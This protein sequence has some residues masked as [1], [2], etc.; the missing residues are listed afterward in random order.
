MSIIQYETKI[1]ISF[2]SEHQYSLHDK[3]FLLSLVHSIRLVNM[4]YYTVTSHTYIYIHTYIHV[5]TYIRIHTYIHTYLH[6]YV[7]THIHTYVR[8]VLVNYNYN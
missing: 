3:I 6:T 7:H 5:L 1:H 8:V 2:N 4:S